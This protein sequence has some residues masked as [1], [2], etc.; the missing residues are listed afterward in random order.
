MLQVKTLEDTSAPAPEP[1]PE[2]QATENVDLAFLMK[3]H[4]L[5]KNENEN[6]QTDE[7][8]PSIRRDDD[9]G[10]DDKIKFKR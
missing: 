4:K 2:V 1:E 3:V 7:T 5:L 8:Q 6:N 10:D 9:G